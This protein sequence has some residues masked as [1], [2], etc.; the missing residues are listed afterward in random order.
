MIAVIEAG[1][2]QY[3]VE[4]GQKIQTE[5]LGDEKAVEFKPLMIIDG[6]NVQ[7]GKPVLENAVVKATVAEEDVK[8][9]KVVIL[10]Y[11]AKKRQS[12]KTGH[13]QKY[14]ELTITDIKA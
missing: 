1:S 8:G 11:K 10:K 14:A 4:K 3:I 6:D 9:K 13:R 12:T 7:V 5:L 2:K